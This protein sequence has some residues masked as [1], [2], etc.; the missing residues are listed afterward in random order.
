[1][2][3]TYTDQFFVMDPGN[4]PP[5]GTALTAVTISYID[6]NDDGWIGTGVGDSAGGFTV[7][8]VWVNDTITVLM[9]GVTVTI[10]GVTFYRSGAPAI[11]TP[12]DGTTLSNATFQS[13]TWVSTST[14][15][16]VSQLWPACFVTGTLILTPT[17]DVPIEALCL[18]D[19]V[20]TRDHGPQPI[21]WIGRKR[22]SGMGKFAPIRFA[23]GA[24]GNA[25]ALLVSP[26]HRMVVRDWRAQLYFGQD[27]MLVAA[28]RLAVCDRIHVCPM[29]EVDYLHLM[30][31]RHEIILAEGAQTE[32]FHAGGELAAV[33][34]DLRAELSELFPDLPAGKL[35][36]QTAL[37][38]AR[39][40][41]ATLLA[42]A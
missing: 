18:G 20:V 10:R 22:V 41:M 7:T 26:Q 3:T 16:Q 42:P 35:H 17:G 31:D 11:F 13:S 33:D 4:P 37:P 23:P 29:P 14:Q 1:M 39:G 28:K 5:L 30:F 34:A 40:P 19:L 9:G 24:M 21:R 38:C 27:E 32:S 36:G 6:N 12:T 8:S 2:P 25:R 15:I